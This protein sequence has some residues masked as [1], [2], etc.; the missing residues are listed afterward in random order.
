MDQQLER[1]CPSFA[2]SQPILSIQNFLNDEVRIL[3][4]VEEPW[5][6]AKDVAKVLRIN[7]ARYMT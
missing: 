4:T 1:L 6:L 2:E 3:G 5:F 7:N